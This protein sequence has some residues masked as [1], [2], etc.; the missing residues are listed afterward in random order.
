M[1]STLCRALAPAAVLLAAASARRSV[2]RAIRSRAAAPRRQ[3]PQNPVCT[4]LEA[5]LA[6]FD[7]GG[8]DPARAEQIRA[9]RKPPPASRPSSTASSAQARRL[10]CES[11]GFFVLFSGSQ[12]AQCGAAQPTRSSRCAAISTASTPTCSACSGGRATRARRPAPRHPGG[13]RAEQLRPAIPRRRR[14]APPQRSGSLFE[15]AV[16][17]ELRLDPRAERRRRLLGGSGTYRTVCVRTCDGFFFPISFSTDAEPLRATTSRPASAC[18]RRP[19]SLLYSHRNPGEDMNQ[20]VSITAASSTR[21]CRTPSSTARRSTA[22]AAA[23]RPGETWAEALKN[24][25]DTHRRAGRH[26]RQRGARQA[27]VAAARRRA[28]PADPARAAAATARPEP[29]PRPQRL[30]AG[31]PRRLP[32]PRRPPATDAQPAASPSR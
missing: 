18:A 13:A 21:R 32:Q 19:R 14:A 7:R 26:R 28:G 1:I 9:T 15:I 23:A 6:A 5:Q 27:A 3:A 20:A 16:R 11:N 31:R 25:D 10:G 4:R 17:P 22:A 2:A 30:R 29:A 8:A 24:V 12:T